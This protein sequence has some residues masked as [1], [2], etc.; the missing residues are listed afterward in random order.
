[1]HSMTVI[2]GIP[3]YHVKEKNMENRSILIT[4]LVLVLVA[5]LVLSCISIFGAGLWIWN[6][7]SS[8]TSPI[9]GEV[10]DPQES[11]PNEEDIQTST[12]VDPETTEVPQNLENDTSPPS[13][14]ESIPS[15]IAS[16]MDEIQMQVVLERGLKPSEAVTRTLYTPDQLNAKFIRDFEEEYSVEEAQTDAITLAAFG[17]LEPDFDL[18][19][20][21]IDLYS[22]QVAGFYD[23]ETKEMVVVQGD[24]FGGPQRLTY[25]HE[26]T[27]ALQDQ[28]YDLEN[29]VGY[30][31]EDC[32]ADSEGCAAVRALIEGDASLT[33][34]NWFLTYATP[35]DQ[36]D[37]MEF[38]SEMD[39]PVYESAPEFII[40]G[41]MFPYEYGYAF[42]ESLHSKG[43]WGTVDRAYQNLPKSTEQ[44]MHPERYPDDVPVM[45][46]L[47]DL[48]D[49]LGSDWKEIERDVMGEFYTYL[50][51]S[52][53]LDINAR[54][55][56]DEA[57]LAAEG[58]GGDSYLIYHNPSD[59]STVM[60][61]QTT[62]D[63][64]TDADEFAQT[65][66]NYANV[67]HGTSSN[68]TW[69]GQDGFH[70][71]YHQ[72]NTTTWILAPNADTA[73]TVWQVVQ[74]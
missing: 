41:F 71:I 19:N 60:V 66:R 48:T 26:Y 12:M 72:G 65:F 35:Q 23:P 47:P 8:D 22:E 46:E 63:T 38:Y 52:Q 57:Q 9:V 1:M 62:W 54:I 20:F 10:S 74:P 56:D 16:Q 3:E 30:N 73:Q 68:D 6:S 42:V 43:G 64:S 61:L 67:R 5:C 18:Y 55:D 7:T 69:Q 40:M 58:W 70:S 53:G 15:E 17:L 4:C 13:S 29:G 45:V 2:L 37:I 34:I 44:I 49:T 50:I 28:N 59:N 27:H 21:Y 32:E 51:L 39:M 14:A 11:S 24:E 36:T 25:A 31:E 33:E